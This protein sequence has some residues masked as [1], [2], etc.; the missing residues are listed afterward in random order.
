[1][2]RKRITGPELSVLPLFDRPETTPDLLDDNG[3]RHDGRNPEDIRPICKSFS[4]NIML[5]DFV[6][7]GQ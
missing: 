3:K 4:L 7:M 1:M 6:Q 5:L 2:D